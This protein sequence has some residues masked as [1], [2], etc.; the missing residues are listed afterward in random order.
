MHVGFSKIRLVLRQ[1]RSLKDKRQVVRS[2]V[3]RLKNGFNV[4]VS[5]VGDRDDCQSVILG[6]STASDDAQS[7]K[8]TLQHVAEA[9][10]A[11]PVA[12]FSRVES[13][14]FAPDFE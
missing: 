11:H 7:V 9:L 10:R 13:E 6:I 1:A 14:D 5:E 12:E 4:S 2:I 3:E 8:S